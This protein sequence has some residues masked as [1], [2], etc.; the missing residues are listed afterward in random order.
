[1]R[2]LAAISEEKRQLL[3]KK[4]QLEDDSTAMKEEVSVDYSVS[5]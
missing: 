3:V 4:T 5:I 1:L 2:Q